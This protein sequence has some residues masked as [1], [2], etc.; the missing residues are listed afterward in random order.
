MRHALVGIHKRAGKVV[1]RVALQGGDGSR[2]MGTVGSHQKGTVEVAQDVCASA[3][4][5]HTVCAIATKGLAELS[6]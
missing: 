1:G 3:A 6:K 2:K 5:G 4:V